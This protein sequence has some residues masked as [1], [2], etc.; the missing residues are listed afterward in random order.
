M[1]WFTKILRR[2]RLIVA[3]GF[4]LLILMIWIAGA[5]FLLD[6][7][8]AVRVL[9]T[10][11]VVFLWLLLIMY[12][13]MQ[14]IR[15]AGMLE[16]SLQAQAEA[17]MRGVRPEKRAEIE[18][19]QKELAAAIESLKKSKIG[20]GRSGK[21][22]LYALPW[23]MMIGPPAAGKT[24]AVKNSGLEF[25]FGADKEFRGVGG[26]RNCDWFFSNSA[27]LL[28]T[29]GRFVTEDEDREEWHAFLDTLKK[30]RRRKPINGVI[31]GMSI[32]DLLN[33][34]PDELEW[35]A[36][37]MR[38]RIDEL[39]QRLGIRFPVYLVF[40]K[41]DL[42]DGFV[43]Y[44]E[45]LNRSEREQIWGCAFTPEQMKS[46][47]LR[48]EFEKEFQLLIDTLTDTRMARL[49]NPLKREQRRK[50]FMFPLQLA[51]IKEKMVAFTGKLFQAN[52]YEENPLFRGFFLTSGTQE[53]LPI[54]R[55]I[56]TISRKFGLPPLPPE[57]FNVEIRPYFIKDL[58]TDVIIPDQHFLIEQTSRAAQTKRVARLAI[59]AASMLA[60]LLFG[61]GV[62]RAYDD[63][64]A[65]MHNLLTGTKEARL[66][67]PRG[68]W[69]RNFTILEQLRKR[70]DEYDKDALFFSL[71]MS[72][73][74]TVLEA[75]RRLYFS[76]I[77]DFV[78]LHLYN[79]LQTRLDDYRPGSRISSEQGINYLKAYL[80]MGDE[81]K[82][83]DESEHEFL[84][85]EL[86]AI[87]AEKLGGS[88][89]QAGV[90]A[91]FAD[92]LANSSLQD[93]QGLL[94]AHMQFFV[95]NLGKEGMPAFKNDARIIKEAR[96]A[97]NVL[98][99]P[100]EVYNNDIRRKG[101]SRLPGS[102]TIA[103][104][105]GGEH[106]G[107]FNEGPAVP[108]LF[109]Q[110]GYKKFVEETIE[111]VSRDPSQEDWVFGEVKRNL[112][113]EVRNPVLLK[114]R[115]EEYYFLEYRKKWWEFLH[116]VTYEKFSNLQAA[117]ECLKTLG[118][119]GISPLKRLL[120]K[121][122]DEVNFD[123]GMKNMLE[124]AGQRVGLNISSHPVDQSFIQLFAFMSGSENQLAKILSKFSEAGI[125]LDELSREA[126]GGAAKN[127]AAQVVAGGGELP[128]ALTEIRRSPGQQD[129]NFQK[130]L[131]T[132]CE[133]PVRLA[134]EAVRGA[135]AGYLN[136]QWRNLVYDKYAS[137]LENTFPFKKSGPDANFGEM[138]AFF[139]AEGELWK[140][141]NNELQPFFRSGNL[142]QPLDWA[143]GYGLGLSAEAQKA[144]RDAKAIRDAL[145]AGGNLRIEFDVQI[146]RPTQHNEIDEARLSVGGQEIIYKVKQRPPSDKTKFEWPGAAGSGA[147]LELWNT[148]G[149]LPDVL[150]ARE[151]VD[152]QW[153]WFKMLERWRPGSSGRCSFRVKGTDRNKEYQIECIITSRGKGNPFTSGF[154]DFRCP[155]Q[156]F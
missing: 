93:W 19:F 10:I 135:A 24:T 152:G 51:V 121:T 69:K 99:T 151:S 146:L 28:D 86:M 36:Q 119:P 38:K 105:L 1:S 21:A 101:F 32:A 137:T 62:Y 65:R 15:S 14:E 118:D 85:T 13:R 113:E 63:S 84:K 3:L 156:L 129:I 35:H 134:W 98:I 141:A 57:H 106:T 81:I 132:L 88:T 80:L 71:G 58:F 6:W 26:T 29:A 44:F 31:V 114:A 27:I 103:T 95:G 12:E 70:I 33:A 59:A 131:V 56:E 139:G 75:A 92:S 97:L 145:V 116:G 102:F 110:N 115:L 143:G 7:S 117:S 130:A 41:C 53:G 150:L 111:S 2:R 89:Q 68:D 30:H 133:A 78:S 112:S 123:P 148:K 120:D 109:T 54:D 72:R 127:F 47:D 83:L 144:F 138:A 79:E 87:L 9:G 125:K 104:A 136:S 126:S 61:F 45:A 66:L 140:F 122:S 128:G 153:G 107:I 108:N 82:R 77:K 67:D 124:K 40:T 74:G 43:E 149:L 16:Q 23:Y 155:Q 76:K 8:L 17:Q 11:I 60:L 37:T 48:A 142:G 90:G 50:V 18:Q 147:K 25:P 100:R 46:P 5:K 73:S 55:A 22:A 154:F 4:I 64:Q 42:L 20:R 34:T 49:S 91:S 96:N 39:I 52:P 94:G